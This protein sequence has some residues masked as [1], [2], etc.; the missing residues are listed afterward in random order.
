MGYKRA[1]GERLKELL[2][3]RRITQLDFS[4]HCGISRITIN[5]TIRAKNK[6]VTFESLV[7]ICKALG[8]SFR[9]F[10]D[11]EYFQD[12]FEEEIG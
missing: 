12:I 9:E 4:K 1:I 8:V 7:S 10:F 6:V 5:R 3:E 11:C 2:K